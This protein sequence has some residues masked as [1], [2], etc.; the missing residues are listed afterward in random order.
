M[1]L[2]AATLA[3]LAFVVG[4]A[5]VTTAPALA[6]DINDTHAEVHQPG[7]KTPT[8]LYRQIARDRCAVAPHHSQAGKLPRARVAV[9]ADCADELADRDRRARLAA[10]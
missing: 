2:R 7:G 6:R 4:A 8:R 3:A 9:P 1:K 5:G 10:N